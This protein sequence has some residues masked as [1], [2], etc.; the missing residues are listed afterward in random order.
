MKGRA[1]PWSAEELA[2]IEARKDHPRRPLHAAFVR[3]FGR[4]DVSADA[5][6]ALCTRRGWKTGRNGRFEKG[7]ISWNKGRAMPFNAASAATRFK[8]GNR[9]GRA[10]QIY[11]PIGTERLSKEGYR[12]RKVHDGMP[13]QSRWRAVHLIEWEARHGPIP[14]GHCL[15]CLDGDKTNAD[16]SNWTLVPRALLPRLN[17]RFGRNFDGAPAALKPVILAIARLEHVA[18]ERRKDMRK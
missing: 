10:N 2:W 15:K 14:D 1:I 4:T 6:K 18:R 8:K 17:G 13:L 3:R 11:K 5:L 9:T 16:P 7:A 12:E